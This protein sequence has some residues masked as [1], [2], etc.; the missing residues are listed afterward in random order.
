MK[1]K[2]RERERERI[3][4]NER[5]RER[6]EREREREIHVWQFT[7]VTGMVRAP[8][9]CKHIPVEPSGP[10]FVHKTKPLCK[11]EQKLEGEKIN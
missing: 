8:L 2:E 3:K 5:E 10:H 7:F 4:Q 1:Q 11:K 9:Q 6:E